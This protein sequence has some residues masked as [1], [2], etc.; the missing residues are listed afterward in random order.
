[1]HKWI[2]H[3]PAH[4][5]SHSFSSLSISL[6]SLIHFSGHHGP[7]L[8]NLNRLN[9]ST[10]F[11]L[12]NPSTNF[13]IKLQAIHHH[14][15]TGA[16]FRPPCAPLLKLSLSK[17]PPFLLLQNPSRNFV[18]GLFPEA[19]SSSSVKLSF[20]ASQRSHNLTL[21]MLLRNRHLL[22]G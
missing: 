16:I 8:P 22:W 19:R 4:T 11:S 12:L 5:G 1:M 20:W 17:G 21:L 3:G 7:P 2:Y 10:L 15:T 13:T 6:P 9:Y 18:Y 14:A